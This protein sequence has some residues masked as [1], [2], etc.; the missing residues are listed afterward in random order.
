MDM[1]KHIIKVENLSKEIDCNVIFDNI[2]LN[3]SEGTICGIVGIN[4]SGKSMLLKAISGLVYGSSGTIKV[5]DTI[6]HNGKFPENFGVLLDSP[7]LLPQYSAF[8]NLKILASI[9][10]VITDN[11]IKDT[12]KLVGLNPDDKRPTKKYSLGMKQKVGIAQALMEKPKL[13]LLDEPMNALDEK[14]ILHMRELILN[15][16]KQ[17]VTI[18]LTSHNKDDIDI[19]CDKVYKIDSGKLTL[20]E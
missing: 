11:Q 20:V 18:V 2:N 1:D 10:N 7:G 15:L 16:K 8:D 14:S 3:I 12:L 13:L 17:K 19:L 9:N 5:F 6:I 4:G